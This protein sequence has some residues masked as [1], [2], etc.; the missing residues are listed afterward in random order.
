MPDRVRESVFAMLGAH[1]ETPGELPPLTV[2]DVFA[3]SGSMGL[4]AL[5]RG[6]ERC[7]FYERQRNVLPVLRANIAA[8]SA[9][10][11]SEV[12]VRDA[13]TAAV[14]TPEGAA[15]DLIMLDPPYRES[16]DDSEGGAVGRY[17]ARVAQGE[18]GPVVILH[19]ERHARFA[20]PPAPNWR[21]VD[22]RTH[23]SNTVT[24]FLP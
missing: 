13:W 2:A 3:G 18:G 24:M 15:Y 10:D 20:A 12:I 9:E 8:L 17:L 19:H 1:F 23:G 22:Q 14:M 4:E 7:I 21:I 16:Q 5:S 6:A 11:M